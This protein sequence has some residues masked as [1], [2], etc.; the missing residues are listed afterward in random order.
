E[1]AGPANELNAKG[2]FV[3]NER[4]ASFTLFLKSPQRVAEDG[5]PA[6]LTLAAP[7]LDLQFSGRAAL[8]N[9]FELDGQAGLKGTALALAASWFGAALPPGLNGARFEIAGAVAT[10]SKGLAFDN[11]QFTLDDM[12]GEGDVALAQ[13][14]GRPEITAKVTA[15]TI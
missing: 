9:G 2:A 13:G 7:G 3:W 10:A 11:A 5:S 4:R 15:Q 14:K 1:L 6:D 12:R 8:L